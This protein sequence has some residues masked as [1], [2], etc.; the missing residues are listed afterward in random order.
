MSDFQTF[1]RNTGRP[2]QCFFQSMTGCS[3]FTGMVLGEQLKC[4]AFGD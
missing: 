4:S 1:G 2:T 3:G